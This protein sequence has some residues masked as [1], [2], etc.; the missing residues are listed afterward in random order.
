MRERAFLKEILEWAP[1]DRIGYHLRQPGTY[2]GLLAVANG[3]D[4]Q[5]AQR[6]SRWRR[7]LTA[8]WPPR[9][10]SAHSKR[11]GASSTC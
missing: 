11:I 7:R 3:L 1:V 5:I 4:Q 10:G 6:L 2:L 9:R 8:T